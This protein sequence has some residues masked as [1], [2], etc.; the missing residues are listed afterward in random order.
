MLNEGRT[1]AFNIEHPTFNIRFTFI[2]LP[3]D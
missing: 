3:P 2:I 1:I